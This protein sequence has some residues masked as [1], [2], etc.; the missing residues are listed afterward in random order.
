MDQPA[1]SRICPACGSGEHKFRS[2][3]KIAADE[4]ESEAVETK[5]RCKGCGKEWRVKTSV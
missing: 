1:T 3:K 2:R 4:G 5:Y